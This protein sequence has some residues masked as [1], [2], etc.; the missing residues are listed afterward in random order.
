LCIDGQELPKLICFKI[1]KG[2]SFNHRRL[3]GLIS[4][5][6]KKEQPNVWAD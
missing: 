5:S 4:Y 2:N 1:V 6:K 3:R